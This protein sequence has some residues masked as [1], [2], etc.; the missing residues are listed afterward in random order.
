MENENKM[1]KNCGKKEHCKWGI[2]GTYHC[3]LWQTEEKNL[4]LENKD[5]EKFNF[6]EI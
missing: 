3:D 1:C 4:K 6:K 2:K 5:K